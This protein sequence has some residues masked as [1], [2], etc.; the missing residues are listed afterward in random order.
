MSFQTVASCNLVDVKGP[1]HLS[2][3]LSRVHV[4]NNRPV[5]VRYHP[6]PPTD[7]DSVCLVEEAGQKMVRDRWFVSSEDIIYHPGVDSEEYDE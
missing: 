5:V 3:E 6:C 4:G 2:R 1:E 7:G